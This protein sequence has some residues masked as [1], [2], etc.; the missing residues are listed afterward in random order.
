M[1]NKLSGESINPYFGYAEM[2]KGPAE[3]FSRKFS[4]Y[5]ICQ[6]L[7]NYPASQKNVSNAGKASILLPFFNSDSLSLWFVR[8]SRQLKFHP[9]QIAFPG[10]RYEAEDKSSVDT[11]LRETKEELGL[12]PVGIDLWGRLSDVYVDVSNNLVSP[13]VGFVHDGLIPRI[14]TDETEEILNFTLEE[15]YL[16]ARLAELRGSPAW[17]F[18]PDGQRIWGMTALVIAELFTLIDSSRSSN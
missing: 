7:E 6:V 8:R 15:L 17:E 10:G 2:W 3:N 11:A 16:S 1:I 9:S 5:Y 13:F 18:H 14:K 4:A 12:D